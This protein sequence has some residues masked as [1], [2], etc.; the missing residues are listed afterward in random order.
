MNNLNI[1]SRYPSSI[2]SEHPL[3]SR[4]KYSIKYAKKIFT[5]LTDSILAIKKRKLYAN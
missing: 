5:T 4:K 3:D 1:N 2:D